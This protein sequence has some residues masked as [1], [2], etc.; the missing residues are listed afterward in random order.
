MSAIRRSSQQLN[1][2]HKDESQSKISR[3]QLWALGV[4]LTVDLRLRGGTV[5]TVDTGV[6]E[7]LSTGRRG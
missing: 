2:A 6:G 5:S 7:W 3:G 4:A 1:I